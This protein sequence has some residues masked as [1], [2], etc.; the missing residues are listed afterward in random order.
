ML[1]KQQLND[2]AERR[3]LLLLESDLHRSVIRLECENMRKRL[4]G[5]NAARE[6]MKAGGPWMVAGGAVASV[7]ALRHWRKLL[8]WAP[9][10]LTALRWVKS[11]KRR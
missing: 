2:L 9:T 5:L 6:R 1:A 7:F 4:A 8:Q 3:R 10:A 11:L